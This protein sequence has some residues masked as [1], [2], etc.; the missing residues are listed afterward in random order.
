MRVAL[1]A[2][3]VRTPVALTATIPGSVDEKL[4]SSVMLTQPRVCASVKVTPL[5]YLIIATAVA[6]LD[7]TSER[8]SCAASGTIRPIDATCAT[9]SS[10]TDSVA[11]ADADAPKRAVMVT[12]PAARVRSRVPSIRTMAESPDAKVERRVM[13]MGG[14]AISSRNARTRA[15]AWWKCVVHAMRPISF[16]TMSLLS[17]S[18]GNPVKSNCTRSSRERKT[19]TDS[20]K[21]T[22]RSTTAVMLRLVAA[23]EE[24]LRTVTLKAPS[25]IGRISAQVAGVTLNVVRG[26]AERSRTDPSANTTSA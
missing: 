14:T 5:V 17:G 6:V 20:R 16:S 19:W 26:S 21:V 3:R 22:P 25:P 18:S 13:V 9:T 11:D 23:H 8:V 1:L 24:P 15:V 4:T 7:A 2:R 12:A 10:A